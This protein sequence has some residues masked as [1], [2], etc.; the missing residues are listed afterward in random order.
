MHDHQDETARIRKT[1]AKRDQ[2]GKPAL[3]TWCKKDTMLTQYRIRTVTAGLFAKNGMED[4]SKTE[5]LDIGCGTGGWLRTLVEWGADPKHLH[6]IELLEDRIEQA[7]HVNKDIDFQV[8][9]GWPIDF[10][11]ASMDLVSAHT[12]FS[13]ILA[14]EAR[15][16]LASEM[17]RILKTEGV[18]F[19][20][21]F[22]ISHPRNPDTIGIGKKEIQRLFPDL[23]VTSRS[24]LLAPP[25]A[26]RI[27]PISSLAVQ[28]LEGI[29]P[30]LRSHA[31]Y[32]LRKRA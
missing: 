18:V 23:T 22:R 16:D 27:A 13:S 28:L 5:V 20:F 14:P 31:V 25:L 15:R 1:Y 12:V 17:T 7:R 29:F 4:L 11:D 26:R 9:S 24:L 3:Y 10:P 8:S 32:L 6:G 30:F 2:A 19:I 21:D